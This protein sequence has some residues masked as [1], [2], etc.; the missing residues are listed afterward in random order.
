LVVVRLYSRWHILTAHRHE[1]SVLDWMQDP[2]YS[3]LAREFG[4]VAL[5]GDRLFDSFMRHEPDESH[6]NLVSVLRYLS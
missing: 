1:R 6:F 2:R 3:H 4:I 5:E